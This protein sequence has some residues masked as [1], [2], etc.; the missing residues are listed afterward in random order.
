MGNSE[1]KMI[2]RAIENTIDMPPI[3][4]EKTQNKQPENNNDSI[5]EEIA[6]IEHHLYK[7]NHERDVLDGIY[8]M[9]MRRG[10]SHQQSDAYQREI[11]SKDKEIKKLMKRLKYYKQK[12]NV[13]RKS[14]TL[15]YN[16]W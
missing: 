9:K 14:N 6:D 12:K 15:E 3:D 5:N 2:E 1:K 10:I 7:L 8:T 11:S 4:N 16:F 13:F